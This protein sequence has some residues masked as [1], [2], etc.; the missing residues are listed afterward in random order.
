M[1]VTLI[2]VAKKANVSKSTVSL[3][4]NNVPSVKEE[5]RQRVLEAI[6]ELGYVP[7]FNA[8]GLMTRRTNSLGVLF[9]S[10]TNT[11][12]SNFDF[13]CETEIYPNDIL[14]GIP[15]GLTNTDYGLVIE[16]YSVCDGVDCPL[17]V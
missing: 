6:E 13:N 5:T 7:N 8:R 17:C 3:V 2:D 15:D 11:T 4:I 1:S 12:E 9:I 10:Q 16:R 14:A